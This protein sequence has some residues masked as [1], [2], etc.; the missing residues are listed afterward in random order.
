MCF[1]TPHHRSTLT[2]HIPSLSLS[3]ST[4]QNDR[5]DEQNQIKG[6]NLPVKKPHST[7]WREHVFSILWASWRLLHTKYR[8]KKLNEWSISMGQGFAGYYI[9]LLV[10]AGTY[11]NYTHLHRAST[12]IHSHSKQQRRPVELTD[13]K[14]FSKAPNV[15]SPCLSH[16]AEEFIGKKRQS[17]A[18]IT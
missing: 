17:T 11:R 14:V 5:E 10:P 18:A 7:E 6:I 12:S 13:T 4:S 2:P 1:I 15:L 9:A 3:N 16:R 8:T